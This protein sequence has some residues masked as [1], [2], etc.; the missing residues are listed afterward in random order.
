VNHGG[1]V[2]SYRKGKK[3]VLHF[4]RQ[5]FQRLAAIKCLLVLF[6]F[7]FHNLSLFDNRFLMSAITAAVLPALSK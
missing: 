3:T 2:F 7:N 5:L 4:W 6:L 1:G